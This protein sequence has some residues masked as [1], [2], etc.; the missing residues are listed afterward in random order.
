MTPYIFKEIDELELELENAE[1]KLSEIREQPGGW[2]CYE[3][4]V[5]L[6]TQE[7]NRLNIELDNKIRQAKVEY[8]EYFE[9]QFYHETSF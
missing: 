9:R 4:Q 8:P 5:Q 6:N 1:R 2:P 3:L 7:V